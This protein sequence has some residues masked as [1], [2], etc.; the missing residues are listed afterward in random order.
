DLNMKDLFRL[1]LRYRPLGVTIEVAGQQG[2]FIPWIKE[3]MQ[4]HQFWFNVIETRPALNKLAYFM[5]VVPL[6]TNGEVIYPTEFRDTLEMREIMHEYAMA[7]PQG[8]K[9][10]HDDCV[11]GTSRLMNI[12]PVKP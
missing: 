5:S 6:I 2:G 9:S 8:L 3:K 7:T 10:K 1:A 11:D 4:E 12:V